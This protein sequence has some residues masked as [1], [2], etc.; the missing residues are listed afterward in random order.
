MWRSVVTDGRSTSAV[1]CHGGQVLETWWWPL[2]QP[3]VDHWPL[4][5]HASGPSLQ[6]PTMALFF[7]ASGNSCPWEVTLHHLGPRVQLNALAFHPL[8]R[9]F[10]GVFC[11]FLRG[12]R[13]DQAP[14][15]LRCSSITHIILVSVLCISLL[16][17]ETTFQINDLHPN[18]CLGFCFGWVQSKTR[19]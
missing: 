1:S 2:S 12:P 6:A 11:K 17:L 15:A 14:G 8:P 4:P 9:Q 16:P 5:V 13:R 18:L 7:S 19:E 3:L 10:Q